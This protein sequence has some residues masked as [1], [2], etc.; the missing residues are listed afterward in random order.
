MSINFKKSTKS[1]ILLLLGFI[2]FMYLVTIKGM[3]GNVYPGV[4][5][6]QPPFETSMERGR[7]AQIVAISEDKTFSVDKFAIFLRPDLAWY[8]GHFYSAFPPGVAILGVPFYMLGNIFQLNPV[9]SFLVSAI[10]SVLCAGALYLTGKKLKVSKRS[11]FFAMLI[12]SLGSVA[13]AYS[14]SLSAHPVSAFFILLSYLL[15]ISVEPNNKKNL[16]LTSLL[17]IVF[18][19]NLFIDYP[20]L[21]IMLPCLAYANYQLLRGKNKKLLVP[22]LSFLAV[23]PVLALFA[24][25]NLSLYDKPFAFSNT[26]NLKR[27]EIQGIQVDYDHLSNSMFEQKSYSQRFQVS[28]F[29]NGAY[30]LLLS[31]DR[32]L[33]FY[34]P[35]FILSFLGFIIGF[36]KKNKFIALAFVVFLF[37]LI[38]YGTF[39]DPYGGWAFGPRYLIPTLPILSLVAA[40]FFDYVWKYAI[41]RI[42]IFLLTLFSIAV[43]ASG[44][45]TT[46]AIPPKV[47][48]VG[49]HMQYNYLL[50]MHIIFSGNVS[51]FIYNTY[52]SKI[53]SPSIFYALLVI[54][55]GVVSFIVIFAK[56]PIKNSPMHASK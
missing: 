14:V 35:I 44:A 40:Y 27:L 5:T 17:W 56:N 42:G 53:F 3:P 7:F 52:L 38:I 49:L 24:W 6:N 30:T 51:S 13:W 18:T 41:I 48:A 37:D 31:T 1:F 8:N 25:Y 47:E 2:F 23:I 45:L 46:N 33:L 15:A 10:F 32:G 36:I 26:Y 29:F 43:A 39:D 16:L 34:S 50:N 21:F 12:F 4:I 55:A 22:I 9:F 11:T 20:N 54:I 28:Q 19:L